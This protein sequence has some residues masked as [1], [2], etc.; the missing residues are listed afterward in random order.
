MLRLLYLLIVNSLILLFFPFYAWRRSRA[1]PQGAWLRVE[2]EGA[3]VELAPRL[4]FWR[5]QK[6]PFA[7]EG[8]RRVIELSAGDPRVTGFLIEIDGLHAGSATATGLREL[9]LHAKARGKRVV[10]YL[11]SGAGTRELYVASAADRILIG[12]ET[13]VTALGFAIEAPYLKNALDR[14]GLRPEVFARGAYK[15][16]G[17]PLLLQQMSDPQREQLGLLLETAWD[18]LVDALASGRN[19]PRDAVERFIN[20]G[21]WPAKGAVDHGFVDGIA[22]PDQLEKQLEARRKDGETLVPAGRYLRRRRI[23]WRRLPK[24]RIG[25]VEVHGPIVSEARGPMPVASEEAV[26]EALDRAREDH[27]VRGAVLHVDSRGGSALASD[28]MLHAVKRLAETK[29]VVACLADSAA[30]GGYMVAVGAHKIVAQPTTVTGS[31]GVV[32]ARVVIGPLLERLGVS[33]EVVKRGARADMHSPTR[34]LLDGERAVIERQLDHVY[35]SFVNAV[36]LGRKRELAEVDAL[37]GGRIWSGR[38]AHARGLVDRLGG[39]EAALS[40]LRALLGPG[41]EVLEPALVGPRRLGPTTL[42]L[43]RFVA[44]LT[45]LAPLRGVPRD[46]ITLC[47]GRN[48]RTFLWCP[49]SETDL[50]AR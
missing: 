26:C 6:R 2:I 48:D 44:E 50:G 13:D 42:G 7:L 36:A 22:Y 8:L 14:A 30:S 41:A 39:F 1:C 4:P 27:S 32:A 12:P 15:T 40:E 29:P 47:Y 49:I 33:V 19:L 43:P 38:D 37:A 9:L 35:R 3:I 18:I 46:L 28:R 45:G 10:V 11:P 25:V 5:R 17:E 23:P 24:P 31:I 21:P 34:Q 20:E 16:A